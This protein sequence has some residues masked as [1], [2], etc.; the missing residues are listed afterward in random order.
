MKASLPHH[1]MRI[2]SLGLG[3][4]TGDFFAFQKTNLD[5]SILPITKRNG[6]GFPVGEYTGHRTLKPVFW[7]VLN[8][9]GE[10][11]LCRCD[12]RAGHHKARAPRKERSKYHLFQKIET[13]RKIKQLMLGMSL[14]FNCGIT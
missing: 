13:F 8:Y 1:G 14:I 2:Y 10:V 11:W 9:F 12:C 6:N 3:K 4:G 7:N 5:P